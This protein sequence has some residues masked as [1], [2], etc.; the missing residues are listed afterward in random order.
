MQNYLFLIKTAYKELKLLRNTYITVS[1]FKQSLE[2]FTIPSL[3][4]LVLLCISEGESCKPH[5]LGSCTQWLQGIF[6]PWEALEGERETGRTQGIPSPPPSWHS[7]RGV[8]G[9]DS[10]VVLSPL[11]K[12]LCL[13]S[14]LLLRQPHYGSSSCWGRSPNT[15]NL[16]FDPPGL[17][18]IAAQS[19]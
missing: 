11:A 4:S 17:Q 9:S 5:L 10:Y 8:S 19:C 6:G 2:T 16:L 3:T 14:Q 18:L 1:I 15:L 12:L 13:W 7:L